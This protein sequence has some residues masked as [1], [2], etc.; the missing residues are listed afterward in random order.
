MRSEEIA[1]T[2]GDLTKFVGSEPKRRAREFVVAS[3]RTTG[4]E[5]GAAIFSNGRQTRFGG[6]SPN[7]LTVPHFPGASERTVSIHHNHPMG[8]SFSR[9]DLRLLLSRAEIFEINAHGHSGFDVSATRIGAA[10]SHTASR[11]V[12]Q[13]AFVIAQSAVKAALQGSSVTMAQAQ[14]GLAMVVAALHLEKTGVIEYTANS[15]ELMSLAERV[16]GHVK[17]QHHF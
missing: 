5:W 1:L 10:L 17:R 7:T 6:E 4:K 13:D 11:Q 3:G 14:G 12:V 2:Y 16:L 15:A 9:A 8:D